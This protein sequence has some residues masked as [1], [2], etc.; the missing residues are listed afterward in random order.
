MTLQS[1]V[2]VDFISLTC[3]E[4]DFEMV[5]VPSSRLI[6]ALFKAVSSLHLA[7]IETAMQYQGYHCGRGIGIA[8]DLYFQQKRLSEVK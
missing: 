3:L 2:F 8:Q 7:P 5:M 4:Y 6:S 1:P